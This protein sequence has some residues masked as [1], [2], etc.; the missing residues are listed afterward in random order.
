M[1][2][3]GLMSGTSLDG[4]DVA[5]VE[6][7]RR[8]GVL[9]VN[10]LHWTT[11]PLGSALRAALVAVLPPHDG[12]IAA[13]AELDVAVGEAFADAALTAARTWGVDTNAV[14]VVASHGQTM[15]HAPESGVTLQIG[16][17]AVIA[18]RTGITCA[19]DFRS[20]DVAHGGQ[21]APLVP[22]VD[23]E[24]FAS[25]SEFR[26]AL[27]IGGIANVTLLPPAAGGD[28]IAAF[29]TGPGNVVID[30]F[31][32]I[33][34]RGARQRDENGS[35]A[36]RGTVD[37]VL[38][39][40]WLRHPFF[41]ARPPKSTGREAFGAGFARA[42]FERATERGLKA[43][44]ALATATA[45]AARS[46]A[47]AVPEEC[48]RVIASGGGTHN[49]TLMAAL[50]SELARAGCDA[51][52]ELTDAFGIPADAKEAVVFACL[53]VDAVAGRAHHL[54]QCTG[55]RHPS[56]LGQIAPGANYARLMQT[57]WRDAR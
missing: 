8:A 9:A 35:A 27:N 24:L 13:L 17:G 50:R 15:L 5:D 54:P 12:T 45:L 38:L 31:A 21:G 36:A 7:S 2:A 52:V 14:D 44:D 19:S 29:D 6:V 20:A 26:V 53:G 40:E 43:D 22:F 49:A 4:I 47:A 30:E 33:A 32:C 25:D 42:A 11:M 28:R 51:R 18:A 23:R 39:E 1:R 41:A 3:F 56:I 16:R 48:V 34:S 46:I 37:E 57:V 55:A 10:V